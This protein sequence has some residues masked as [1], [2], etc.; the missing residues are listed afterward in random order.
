MP[1]NGICQKFTR[2]GGVTTRYGQG[3]YDQGQRRCTTCE[4]FISAI[5]GT[6]NLCPC[7]RSKLRSRPRRMMFKNKFRSRIS[8]ANRELAKP[9]MATERPEYIIT[10]VDDRL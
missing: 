3:R 9:E 5:L 10:S 4:I 6:A 7:C 2:M 1:C 8:H